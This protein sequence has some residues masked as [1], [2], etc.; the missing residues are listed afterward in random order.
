LEGITDGGGSAVYAKKLT[1]TSGAALAVE[2]AS[3]TAV[4]LNVVEGAL[5]CQGAGVN[6]NTFVFR[7]VNS[8]S[9]N[10]FT[11]IDNPQTNGRPDCFLIATP[12]WTDGQTIT[13]THPP[14][15]VYYHPSYDKWSLV[16]L[17][18]SVLNQAW[19]WNIM[20]IRP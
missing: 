17:D 16:T 14:V 8:P 9:S 4:A 5:R 3:P 19:K 1:N 15:C 12:W 18:G 7:H 11:V 10:V 20:V 13:H 2:A 6:T